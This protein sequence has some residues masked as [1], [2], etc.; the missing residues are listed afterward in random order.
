MS[1][2]TFVPDAVH[3]TPPTSRPP[4]ERLTPYLWHLLFFVSIATLFE[5]YDAVITGMA[6]PALGKD[7]GV[8][9]KELGF[10]MSLIS[11]GTIVAFVPVQM[12]DRYGRRPILLLVVTGY[13]IFTI[14]TALSRGLYDFVAYQFIARALMVTEVGVGAVVLA[15]ELPARSRGMGVTLMIGA[16]AVGFLLAAGLF[17]L[18]ANTVLGWRWLYLSGGGLL[19]V[20]ALYWRR[21]QET[22][23][24]REQ[25]RTQQRH[26][27]LGWW[28]GAV[29]W[30]QELRMV[31]QPRQ[32]ARLFAVTALWFSTNFWSSTLMYFFPY[33]VL[34]ERSWTAT[35]LSFTLLLVHS[36]ALLGYGLVGPLLDGFGRRP[37]V[38]LYF[39]LAGASTIVCFSASSS[40]LIALGYFL[41][42]CMMAVWTISATIS[43][44][45]FPTSMR[46]TANAVANNL[47]GRIGMVIAP[48]C[49]GLLVSGVGSVGAAVAVLS[50]V[51]WVCIPLVWLFLPET[52]QKPLEEIAEE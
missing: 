20:V 10:A 38:S 12:A 3:P 5:G 1:S 51:A 2:V 4:E 16:G 19:P 50:P 9:P 28:R 52:R 14:L 13:S 8:G 11:I 18:F 45:V 34:N 27:V 36:V 15:E 30:A 24:W 47:L 23:R 6:L 31:Y 49:T 25:Q 7:F 46:A 44:E 42:I 40:L 39:G 33:Y 41:S 17:S 35:Q 29:Q 43:A 48:A 22:Q 37:T 32:R 26:S 21:L